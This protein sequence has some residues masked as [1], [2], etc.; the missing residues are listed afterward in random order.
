[1]IHKIRLISGFFYLLRGHFARQLM[2][3]RCDHL[4]M[5]QLLCADISKKG[6]QLRVRHG[7]ALTQVSQRRAQLSVRASVLTNNKFCQRRVWIFD[8]YGILQLLFVLKHFSVLRP[9]AAIPRPRILYPGVVFHA[10]HI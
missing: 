2:N 10:K 7:I 4:K 5:S 8:I 3:D 9:T 1:M 6:F